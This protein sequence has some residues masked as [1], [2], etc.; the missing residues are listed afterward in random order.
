MFG[1]AELGFL[2]SL[3]GVGDAVKLFSFLEPLGTGA[4]LTL[5]VLGGKIIKF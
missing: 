5:N 1:V 4:H 2:G 3:L